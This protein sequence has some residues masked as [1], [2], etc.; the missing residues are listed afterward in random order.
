[1]RHG[2]INIIYKI[3]CVT[4][5]HFLAR[6]SYNFTIHEEIISRLARESIKIKTLL[7]RHSF[8]YIVLLFSLSKKSTIIKNALFYEGI[9]VFCR[10]FFWRKSL[11]ILK[12][13]DTLF[14]TEVISWFFAFITGIYEKRFFLSLGK[15]TCCRLFFDEP[16]GQSMWIC[17]RCKCI[18]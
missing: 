15:F 3:L 9:N 4:V 10:E 6:N 11:F 14:I 7:I 1:L 13:T 8:G 5:R 17:H 12:I 2:C 18:I 16:W